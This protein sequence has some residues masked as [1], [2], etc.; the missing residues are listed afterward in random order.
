MTIACGSATARCSFE[1]TTG[2]ASTWLTVHIAV[3]TAGTVERT[4]ARSFALL[5][6]P[7]RT[8]AAAKPF[9]Q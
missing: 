1:T 6:I 9:A 2:A 4:T 7:A 5:R 8:P 3:P